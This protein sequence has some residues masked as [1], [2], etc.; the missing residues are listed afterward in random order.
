MEL[1]RNFQG[2]AIRFDDM[3]SCIGEADII[4]TSTGS[5]D[6]IINAANIQ[7]ALAKRKNN[8]LFFIDI[9]VPRDVDP[10]V[11]E[12]DNVYLYDIDDLKEV[13]E[14]NVTARKDEAK[15]AKAI[16]EEEISVFDAWLRS[17]ELQP[18]IVAL[19]KRGEDIIRE[20]IALTMRHLG[21]KDENIE[22]MLMVMGNSLLKKFHHA[23]L[24]YLKNGGMGM[25]QRI[26][27]IRQVFQLDT[28]EK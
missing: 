10:D 23:P 16:V 4:I 2:E 12:I 14:E 9:A 17:L 11:N 7:P 25:P 13:V 3:F 15:K 28:K 1:A 22:K 21:Q 19:N 6:P 8:P 24:M 5:R 18:T 27:V 26:G 20:E